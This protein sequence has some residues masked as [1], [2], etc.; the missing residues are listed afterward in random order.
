VIA[1]FINLQKLW[2]LPALSSHCPHHRHLRGGFGSRGG[3]GCGCGGGGGGFGAKVFF[4]L[5]AVGATELDAGRLL[6][7]HRLDQVGLGLERARAAVRR[8]CGR[9]CASEGHALSEL[10]I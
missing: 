6:A 7:Q 2:Y 3:C 10:H 1:S 8:M 4:E 9:I 5:V